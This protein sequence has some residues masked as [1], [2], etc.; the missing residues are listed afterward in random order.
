MSTL[1]TL[2]ETEE[3][4]V[5]RFCSAFGLTFEPI[6]F[7][8]DDTAFEVRADGMVYQDA[9]QG[10]RE[11]LDLIRIAAGRS[12]REVEDLGGGFIRATYQG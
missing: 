9:Y 2:D 12:A 6:E 8:L 10:E 4:L 5:S 7:Y 1:A 3:L 11:I